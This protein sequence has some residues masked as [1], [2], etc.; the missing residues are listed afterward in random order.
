MATLQSVGIQ[1]TETDSSPVT[2]AV[3]ASIGAYVGHFNWG[4]ADEPI[5]VTSEKQLGEIFGT[6]T[7]ETD[8]NASSYLTAESFLKYGD[9]LKVIRAVPEAHKN[10][11]GKNIAAGSTTADLSSVAIK[12]FSELSTLQNGTTLTEAF[13]ARCIGKLGDGLQVKVFHSDNATTS[14]TGTDSTDNKKEI[15]SIFTFSPNTTDWANAQYVGD[16]NLSK[17]EIH[18]VVYDSTG[19]FTGTKGAVLETWQGLSLDPLARTN[20]GAPNYFKTV[21]NNGSQY[22]FVCDVADIATKTSNVWALV[23]NATATLTGVFNFYGGVG[24]MN[25]SGGASAAVVAALKLL[26]DVDNIKADLIFAEAF[27]EDTTALVNK[28]LIA[29]AGKR[30]DSMVFCSAPVNLYTQNTNAAKVTSLTAHRAA[31]G[32]SDAVLS[33]A[34]NDSTPLY[35]YNKYSDS[36]VWIP[37][38]G[39]MAGLCA[40]TD[41]IADPWFSPAGFN[42]GQLRG[43]TKL[44]FSPNVAERD[45]LYNSNIN[46]IISV[47]GQ[48]VVL[49]GDKTGQTRPSAFDRINVRR[50]FIALQRTISNAA[51]YQL[52]ELNDEFTRNTFINTVEP[53]LRDVQ[54]RRGIIDYRIVC[55][56]TNN[57][58]QVIDTNR[59]VAD[60][61]IK[62]ARSI[63]Y[64]SLN[65]IATRTGVSFTEIGA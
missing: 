1:V 8:K 38:C 60:I 61:F 42:R 19:V 24:G 36:Y 41:K 22:I 26:Y 43:V 51:K 65:F 9:A 14:G 21:I 32:G 20:S 17:D 58:G 50:L 48:G 3:S 54:G 28:E 23:T 7:Y 57:T 27:A 25:T 56:E 47:A 49:Y 15:L 4:P 33:Y 44:A 37:A 40:Y 55:D 12:N 6:P 53:Y 18:V 2:Q 39:H 31:A 64:I 59:F 62:P 52:F 13:Y 45:E 34:V 11:Y 10:A 46:P 63:N 29:V 5:L 16:D 30:L 35:V